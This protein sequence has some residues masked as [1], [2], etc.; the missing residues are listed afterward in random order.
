MEKYAVEEGR[1]QKEGEAPK[2]PT[3]LSGLRSFL[4]CH[5]YFSRHNRLHYSIYGFRL[6]YT[7]K[8]FIR[9]SPPKGCSGYAASAPAPRARTAPRNTCP[10]PPSTR[11]GD[12]APPAPLPS[13]SP[14]SRPD[15][16]AGRCMSA[17]GS[18]MYGNH[19]SDS[20]SARE[21]EFNS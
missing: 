21:R 17:P 12:P 16:R 3:L 10:D 15:K 14:A 5:A 13:A 18:S 9:I 2:V 8:F 6:Q 19:R 4:C 11:Q 7:K 20:E 1:P